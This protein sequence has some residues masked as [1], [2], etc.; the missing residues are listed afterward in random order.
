MSA[1]EDC[2]DCLNY[3]NEPYVPVEFLNKVDST[4]VNVAIME[5]NSQEAGQISFFMDTTSSFLFPLSMEGDESFISFAYSLSPDF[6]TTESDTLI[7]S[8]E[9]TLSSDERN[10]VNVVCS[11][12]E[13]SF[14]SFDQAIFICR[15]TLGICNSNESVLRIF[16]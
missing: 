1:C 7:F 12:T 13:L 14:S 11:K 4:L 5:F 9:R 8:Y 15:D 2:G 10:F 6:S 3:D 16:L